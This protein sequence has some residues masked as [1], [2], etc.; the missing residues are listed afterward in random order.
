MMIIIMQYNNNNNNN[1]N[2]TPITD[3]FIIHYRYGN[4]PLSEMVQLR[5]CTLDAAKDCKHA[6]V[7]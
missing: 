6:V 1:N 3:H 2:N 7:L 5:S 4:S